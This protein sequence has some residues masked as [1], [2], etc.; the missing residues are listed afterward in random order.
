MKKTIIFLCFVLVIMGLF[1]CAPKPIST[2]PTPKP[3]PTPFVPSYDGKIHP[4]VVDGG[5]I[6]GASKNG[7]F[8]DYRTYKAN[9][10][11]LG[12]D[13]AYTML[14]PQNG[15][16][17]T[18]DLASADMTFSAY[19]IE[20]VDKVKQAK[21]LGDYKGG[22][23][24]IRT[25]ASDKNVFLTVPFSGYDNSALVAVAGN[26]SLLPR[27]AHYQ[28]NRILVDMNG[29]NKLEAIAC[30]KKTNAADKSKQTAR[31][32]LL[33]ETKLDEFDTLSWKTADLK[34]FDFYAFDLNADNIMEIL[35]ILKTKS[36]S[37]YNVYQLKENKFVK[38]LSYTA[39]Q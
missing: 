35:L 17:A 20:V 34:S 9:G 8:Y 18:T 6:I 5:V 24:I 11:K 29:D 25:S 21:R 10:T 1:A 22:A 15:K 7:V 31:I 4:I 2:S 23:P 37:M 33:M 30:L 19:G 16:T 32:T 39:V 12:E 36:Q 28:T 26:W 14:S 3:T 27:V 38:V 13:N